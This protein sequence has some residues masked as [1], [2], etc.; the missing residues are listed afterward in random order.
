MHGVRFKVLKDYGQIA[1]E[2]VLFEGIVRARHHDIAH[3]LS[4]LPEFVVHDVPLFLMLL[5]LL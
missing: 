1:R 4:D 3:Q 2:V 5:R